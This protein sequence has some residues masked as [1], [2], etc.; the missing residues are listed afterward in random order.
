MPRRFYSVVDVSAESLQLTGREAHHLQ[1]VLRMKPGESVWLFDG[2]G[3]EVLAEILAVG[4][5]SIR[6]R[7]TERRELV[8][9]AT[10]PVTIATGVPKG[11]RFRWLIEKATEL[12]VQRIVP[13]V[14]QRSIVDPGQGK[15]DK[16]RQTIVESCKQSG[17][18]RLM[19]LTEPLSWR[20]CLSD[21]FPGREV[22][23]AHPHGEPLT[24]Q[25]LAPTLPPLFLIGPEG[26]FTD[27]EVEEAIAAGARR[28]QLGPRI[29]RIETAAVAIATLTSLYSS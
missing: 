20:E 10:L 13:L 12:G 5:D 7:V 15:L 24:N 27:S 26:G 9:A 22:W 14:T 23:I 25:P 21:E 4:S 11:D 28:M 8:Q 2:K 29:L 16:L 1:R 3:Q 19:E 18:T 17:R 6:L